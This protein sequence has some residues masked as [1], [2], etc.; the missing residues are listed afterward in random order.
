MRHL[1]IPFFLILSF[2]PLQNYAQTSLSTEGCTD[3]KEQIEQE[4]CLLLKIEEALLDYF[5]THLDALHLK[6]TTIFTLRTKFKLLD[7]GTIDFSNISSSNRSIEKVAK[8]FLKGIKIQEENSGLIPTTIY[9]SKTFLLENGKLESDP[10]TLKSR[11]AFSQTYELTELGILPRFK[12]CKGKNSEK[13]RKCLSKKFSEIIGQNFD[14]S[15]AEKAN[16]PEGIHRIFVKFTISKEGIVE[17]ID[18]Q[19]PH[20]Q[21]ENEA[22][23]VMN[24]IPKMK[25]G[26]LNGTPVAVLY[27]LPISFKIEPDKKKKG[28]N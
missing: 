24:L 15:I 13:L 3:K 11:K 10:I 12:S 26:E 9:G 4:H 6:Q 18:V 27:A 2:L 7:N 28:G 8:T 5:N 1:L 23:R 22:I 17:N 16:L 14:M 20:P 19:A 25:P 21:L